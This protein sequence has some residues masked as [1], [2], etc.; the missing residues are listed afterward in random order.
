MNFLPDYVEITKKIIWHEHNKKKEVIESRINLKPYLPCRISC[1]AHTTTYRL[2]RQDCY[3]RNHDCGNT[4]R[5]L[6]LPSTETKRPQIT[7]Y[8]CSY[9]NQTPSIRPSVSDHDYNGYPGS[10]PFR[11]VRGYGS[12]KSL[13][14]YAEFSNHRCYDRC[15]NGLLYKILKKKKKLRA[16]F[17]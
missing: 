14:K 17:T 5:P 16:P 13:R 6:L 9:E 12:P 11:S 2:I 3:D 8:A 7:K 4:D 15:R 1:N 10:F